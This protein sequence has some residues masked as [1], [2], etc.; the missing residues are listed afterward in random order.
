M[1]VSD[2]L[3]LI[4]QI[5]VLGQFAVNWDGDGKVYLA[6]AAGAD[7]SHDL[8]WLDDY[9]YIQASKGQIT[10]GYHDSGLNVITG[11]DI[12]ITNLLQRAIILFGLSFRMFMVRILVAVVYI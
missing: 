7:P 5:I 3:S 10:Q 8:I 4:G 12:D 11:P 6:S 1:K 2:N 9:V